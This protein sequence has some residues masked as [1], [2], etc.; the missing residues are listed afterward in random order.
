M[1]DATRIQFRGNFD[2]VEAF[3]GWETEFRHGTL[4]IN[5]PGGSFKAMPGDWIVRNGDGT[6]R[7]K[8]STE[9]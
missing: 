5:T 2:E 3:I 9:P 8:P 4:L 1:P 7:V 6:L